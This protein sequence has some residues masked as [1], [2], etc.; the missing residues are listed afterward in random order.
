MQSK[1][2]CDCVGKV[3]TASDLLAHLTGGPSTLRKSVQV[4]AAR[5]VDCGRVYFNGE[6]ARVDAGLKC[7]NCAYN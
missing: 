6:D 2:V 3:W 1:S 4:T 7:G 5:C